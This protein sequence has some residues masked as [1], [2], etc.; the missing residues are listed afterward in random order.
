M[1]AFRGLRRLA[2]TAAT[3]IALASAA[4]AEVRIL[5][6]GDSLTSGQGLPRGRGFVPQLQAW[7]HDHGAGDVRV[8][9]GGISGDTTGGG[10]RRIGRALGPDIDGVIVEL[11]AN[12]MLRGGSPAAMAKNLDGILTEI[13]RHRLPSLLAGL[14]PPPTYGRNDARAFK[15]I[16]R[17][18]A[19]KHDAIYV[20][21]FL[22]GMGGR[23]VREVM[24][25]IQPDGLHPTAEGVA[26]NVEAI[27]PDVLKLVA[28]A[29]T[30][31]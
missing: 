15:A 4:T 5:A 13:D 1:R 8:V 18:L 17:D 21:S 10:L 31:Q 28:R 25:L 3:V 19:R 16:F 2:L 6:F 24:R 26:L 23:S 9:N 30:R 29:R 7:L 11:G 27:G 14:P 20:S 22:G 12:D